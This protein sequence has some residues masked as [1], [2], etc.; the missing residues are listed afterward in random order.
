[1]VTQVE[2]VYGTTRLKEGNISNRASLTGKKGVDRFLERNFVLSS[3]AYI[4]DVV[5]IVAKSLLDTDSLTA[6]T[7]ILA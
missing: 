1:M 2:A 3:K 7:N 6:A 5:V 4:P